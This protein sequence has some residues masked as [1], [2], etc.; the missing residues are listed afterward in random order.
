MVNGQY[1]SDKSPLRP[2][3]GTD[4]LVSDQSGRRR[5]APASAAI[6]RCLKALRLFTLTSRNIP[7]TVRVARQ[8]STIQEAEEKILKRQAAI[9]LWKQPET[10]QGIHAFPT[11]EGKQSRH[12]GEQRIIWKDGQTEGD[13]QYGFLIVPAYGPDGSA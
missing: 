8:L 3:G 12:A 1:L 9:N 2:Y 5:R 11:R 7:F 13:D 10:A 4:R 6:R